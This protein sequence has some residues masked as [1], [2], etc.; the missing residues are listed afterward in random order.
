MN[1]SAEITDQDGTICTRATGN[2]VI[3]DAENFKRL[4]GQE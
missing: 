4:V 3:V 2:Y 1:F